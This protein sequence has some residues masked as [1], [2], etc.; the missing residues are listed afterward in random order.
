[1]SLYQE[2]IDAKEEERVAVEKRRAL[3]DQMA[4]IFQLND[5][6]EGTTSIKDSGYTIKV[7][8]RFNKTINADVLQDI[9]N[10]EGLADQLSTLFRWKPE[11]NK[12]VWDSADE[13]ITRPL[14][15][16]ITVKAGRPSFS[17]TAEDK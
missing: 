10:Q 4:V 9:A 14:A 6:N 5:Q 17:I 13:S 12:K 2:W 1:M 16:A 8:Q 15:E 7:V 3:E 11:I